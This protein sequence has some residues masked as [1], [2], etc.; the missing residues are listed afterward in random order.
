MITIADNRLKLKSFI[1]KISVLT[2]V[3]SLDILTNINTSTNVNFMAMYHFHVIYMTI[4]L[5]LHCVSNDYCFYY[6]QTSILFLFCYCYFYF[7]Y[8]MFF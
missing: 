6:K 7:G 3:G 8:L 1:Q 5:K 2:N 4:F